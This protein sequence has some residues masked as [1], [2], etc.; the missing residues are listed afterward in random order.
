MMVRSRRWKLRMEI[1]ERRG[2]VVRARAS[3]AMAAGDS[4]WNLFNL[5]ADLVSI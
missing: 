3:F 5:F 4:R 1:R 2:Y